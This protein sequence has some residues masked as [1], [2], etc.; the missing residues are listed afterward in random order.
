MALV[1]WSILLYSKNK[2]AFEAKAA[3]MQLELTLS[4]AQQTSIEQHEPYIKLVEKYQKQEHMIFGEGLLFILTLAIG[5]WL[6]NKGFVKEIK[7]AEQQKNFLLS[8]THELKSPLAGMKLALE[9]IRKHELDHINKNTLIDHGLQDADRLENLIANLLLAS[10]IDGGYQIFLEKIFLNNILDETIDFH[11]HRYPETQFHISGNWNTPLLLDHAGIFTVFKNL[12]ENASKYNPGN[13]AINCHI[14]TIEGNIVQ[15]SI[16]DNGYGIPE[17]EQH[18][19]FEK[20][21]R[22]GSEDTRR[23]KGTGLGL[24]LVKGIIMAHKGDIKIENNK[25]GGTTF[26]ITI[27]KK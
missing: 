8:I 15:I 16:S 22:I 4:N 27:P 1:W 3:I 18:L 10:R 24:Y 20:F 6:M 14:E 7:L 9:T 26:I 13:P 17:S 2:E 19:V 12:F 21:Y 5:I 23:T 11:H 25:N